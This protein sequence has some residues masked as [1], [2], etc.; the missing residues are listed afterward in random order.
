MSVANDGEIL[1]LPASHHAHA[2]DDAGCEHQR[3]RRTGVIVFR[4]I[5][6][7]PIPNAV[8]VVQ[9][10]SAPHAP[11]RKRARRDVHPLGRVVKGTRFGWP[12]VV[13]AVVTRTRKHVQ[14]PR[15]RQPRHAPAAW[16][17]FFAFKGVGDKP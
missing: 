1:V 4:I 7:H 8:E 2:D 15:G 17:A 14:K 6:E 16:S 5:A 12:A 13:P 3:D 11:F 10:E 9:Y